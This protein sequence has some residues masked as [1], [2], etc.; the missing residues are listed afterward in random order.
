MDSGIPT[1]RGPNLGNTFES[2]D[3]Q[4]LGWKSLVGRHLQ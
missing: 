3:S 2:G 1:G 4:F